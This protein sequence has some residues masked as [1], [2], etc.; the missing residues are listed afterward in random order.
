MSDK[1]YL[2]WPFF[3]AAHRAL[4]RDLEAWA[5]A[6]IVPHGTDTDA[7]CRT[8]VRNLGQAGWLKY[9]VPAAYG[10]ARE[11]IDSRSLCILRETL[12]RHD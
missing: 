10:G 9:C 7:A 5:A 8:L 1:S 4:E 3:D 2:D 12:G 6:H 11:Q